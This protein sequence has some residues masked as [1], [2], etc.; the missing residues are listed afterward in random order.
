MAQYAPSGTLLEVLDEGE[1]GEKQQ[2][3]YGAPQ[4]E[5]DQVGAGNS[6]GSGFG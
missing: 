1:G 6:Q 4:G 5:G 2:N 3:P